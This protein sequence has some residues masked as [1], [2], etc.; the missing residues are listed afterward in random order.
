MAQRLDGLGV[1]AAGPHHLGH[2]PGAAIVGCHP[3]LDHRQQAAR[4]AAHLF[5]V[6]EPGVGHVVAERLADVLEVG[7]GERDQDGLAHG[8]RLLQ[9]CVHGRVELGLIAIDESFM[10]KSGRRTVKGCARV[11]QRISR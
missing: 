8:R 6:L 9:E 1:A 3:L 5:E 4:V 10:H 11:S 7:A 2:D